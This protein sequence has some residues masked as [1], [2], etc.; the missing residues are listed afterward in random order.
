[1][2]AAVGT[3]H[4]RPARRLTRRHHRPGII[5]LCA[6]MVLAAAGCPT[7]ERRF[8]DT[9]ATA[10]HSNAVRQSPL[11]P[12]TPVP[13][14]LPAMAL[15]YRETAYA[16]SEGAKFFVWYN[17]AGCHGGNGG[18]GMGPPLIDGKWVYGSSPE[19]VYAT[20]ME[21]RP[22][23]MPS[24]RGRI[25]ESQVWQIVAYVR[26]L[27]G[28]TPQI[29]RSARTDHMMSLPKSQALMQEDEPKQSFLPPASMTP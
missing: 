1:M 27:S 17:C 7:E 13:D 11:K 10:S 9:L 15:P 21:G 25:P 19:N 23:G 24:W 14:T 5:V 6:S 8:P 2:P 20:I 16:I 12:G 18:G 26:T 3:T 22:N 29:A 4:S 28:L